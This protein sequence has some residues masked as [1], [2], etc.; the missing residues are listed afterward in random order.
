M[1]EKEY[2]DIQEE[3]K[4]ELQKQDSTESSNLYF[5]FMNW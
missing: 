3:I 4:N 5:D 2:N 1:K